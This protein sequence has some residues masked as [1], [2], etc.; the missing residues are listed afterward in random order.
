MI[1]VKKEDKS[2]GLDSN[3]SSLNRRHNLSDTHV[4]ADM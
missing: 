4:E 3:E 2:G 1:R